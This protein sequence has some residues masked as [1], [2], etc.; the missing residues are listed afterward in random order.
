MNSPEFPYGGSAIAQCARRR[1]WSPQP[2]PAIPA[3]PRAVPA[4]IR[5]CPARAAAGRPAAGRGPHWP[6]LCGQVRFVRA[7]NGRVTLNL[8]CH[9]QYRALWNVIPSRQHRVCGRSSWAVLEASERNWALAKGR[10][11]SA[12]SD[13]IGVPD[14]GGDP[15]PLA[16]S[17]PF[18]PTWPAWQWVLTTSDRWPVWACAQSAVWQAWSAKPCR[19]GPDSGRAGGAGWR[20]GGA[21]AA[22]SLKAAGGWITH[23]VLCS[24]G[25]IVPFGRFGSPVC[26]LALEL[27]P[28]AA[29]RVLGVLARHP[30]GKFGVERVGEVGDV[31]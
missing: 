2:A 19:P 23:C 3:A 6:R 15:A 11:L 10:R 18:P 13:G 30:L 24:L 20:R 17:V 5:A 25:L 12:A 4:E 29:V 1:V 22:R 21:A 28:V 27:L 16:C 8:R 26:G 31:A 9:L 7:G 14:A